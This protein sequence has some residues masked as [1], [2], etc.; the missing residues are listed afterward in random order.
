M[1]TTEVL[2]RG[3]ETATGGGD[4]VAPPT[5]PGDYSPDNGDDDSPHIQE[6]I[7]AIETML[8]REAGSSDAD[9]SDHPEGDL[10]Y[11]RGYYMESVTERV[12]PVLGGIAAQRVSMDRPPERQLTMPVSDRRRLGRASLDPGVAALYSNRRALRWGSV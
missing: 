4:D 8:A 10:Q 5:P 12:V 3:P 9:E 7:S 6:G 11:G 1:S 2:E